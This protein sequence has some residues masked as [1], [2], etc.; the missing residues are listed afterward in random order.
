MSITALCSLFV[1][2]QDPPG[3][4]EQVGK[5]RVSRCLYSIPAEL[6]W[7]CVQQNRV[8]KGMELNELEPSHEYH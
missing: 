4:A 6:T 8:S 2:Q 5:D 7:P 1:C 3:A